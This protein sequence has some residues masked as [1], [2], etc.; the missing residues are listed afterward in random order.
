MGR[1][2]LFSQGH[3]Q[4]PHAIDLRTDYAFGV[5]STL[6]VDLKTQV[7]SAALQ[8]MTATLAIGRHEVQVIA[9]HVKS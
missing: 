8:E 7:C 1:F 2:A 5:N 9:R 3:A 6:P 4:R